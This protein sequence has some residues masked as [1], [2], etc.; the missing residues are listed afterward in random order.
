MLSA[1]LAVLVS[2]AVLNGSATQTG[3]HDTDWCGH[4]LMYD[5]VLWLLDFNYSFTDPDQHLHYIDHYKWDY[6]WQSY[7]YNHSE[8]NLCPFH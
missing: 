1:A 7:I 5:G 8:T 6:F 2:L 4:D 3:A